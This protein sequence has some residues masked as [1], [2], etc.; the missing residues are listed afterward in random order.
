[1]AN[2][3]DDPSLRLGYWDPAA[4]HFRDAEGGELA[5][6]LR[7]SG[8]QWTEIRRDG[9]PV[10]ALDSDDALAENP[11]LVDAAASATLFAVET[12]RLEGELRRSQ[13]RLWRPPTPSGVGSD[14]ISTTPPSSD[15]S[16]SECI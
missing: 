11:E 16:P 8:R 9:L 5:Q 4:G 10:A 1:M 14:V 15:S 13:A 2:A 3:L 6:T 12:G 7:V